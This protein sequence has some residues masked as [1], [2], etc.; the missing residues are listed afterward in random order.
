M[1]IPA[2]RRPSWEARML[3]AA[4]RLFAEFDT[5][6]V[7]TVFDTIG[8]AH[9][10]LRAQSRIAAAAPEQIETLARQ[11]LRGRLAGTS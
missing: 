5:L 11:Q 6:P 9:A 4:D 8:T 10:V 1:L 7:R 2:H 3:A